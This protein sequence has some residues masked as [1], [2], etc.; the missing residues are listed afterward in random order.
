MFRIIVIFFTL[1][2][3][4]CAT[5]FTPGARNLNV[6]GSVSSELVHNCKKIGSVAGY[7]QAGWGNKVG[8]QQAMNDALN[9]AAEIPNGDTFA[10]SNKN[11]SFSGGQVNGMV[12]DC[13][14]ERTQPIRIVSDENKRELSDDVFSK[15]KKCQAKGGVWI[16]DQCVIQLD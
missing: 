3:V 6:V 12:F 9:K 8:L 13:S 14:Q 5:P 15:A 1:F 2:L 16:N 11:R 7:A 4:S 10:V